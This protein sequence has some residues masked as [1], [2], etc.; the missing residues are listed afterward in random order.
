MDKFDESAY[1]AARRRYVDA[2][3]N[4]VEEAARHLFI[5]KIIRL[6]FDDEPDA[7]GMAEAVR[8]E[9][10]LS[11][12]QMQQVFDMSRDAIRGDNNG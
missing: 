11:E 6:D 4:W 12:D 9:F 3:V 2:T 7:Y 1:D 8:T 5:K 10:E